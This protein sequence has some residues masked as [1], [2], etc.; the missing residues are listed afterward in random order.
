MCSE[1]LFRESE[2]LDEKDWEMGLEADPNK[3][4]MG[5]DCFLDDAV[6]IYESDVDMD[7]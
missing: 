7:D 1:L 4:K 5:W 3:D 6:E 2:I